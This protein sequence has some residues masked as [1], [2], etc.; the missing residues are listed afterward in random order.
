MELLLKMVPQRIDPAHLHPF[1]CIRES[2]VRLFHRTGLSQGIAREAD[3][4]TDVDN[5]TTTRPRVYNEELTMKRR[6]MIFLASRLLLATVGLSAVGVPQ[7]LVTEQTLAASPRMIAAGS[8]VL[9]LQP[10]QDDYNR[11]FRD[12]Y[13][14]GHDDSLVDGKLDCKMRPKPHQQALGPPNA[15][16]QGFADGYPKGYE[17]GY[18]RYCG[19]K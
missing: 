12:G 8:S 17:A 15:Y 10:P 16:Q 2:S 19:H 5:A 4:S 7:S 11:G 3:S 14:Q 1:G 9:L 13:R 18:A 6:G